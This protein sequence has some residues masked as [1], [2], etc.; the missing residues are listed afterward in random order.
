MLWSWQWLDR[1]ETQAVNVKVIIHKGEKTVVEP[2]GLYNLQAL[3]LLSTSYQK[4]PFPVQ[5]LPLQEIAEV[6]SFI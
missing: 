6:S 4:P 1:T 5:S 3:T 2:T